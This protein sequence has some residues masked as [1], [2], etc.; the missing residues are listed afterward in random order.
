VS[1]PSGATAD[2]DSDSTQATTTSV[3]PSFSRTLPHKDSVPLAR[4]RLQIDEPTA[5]TSTN[6][7]VSPPGEIRLAFLLAFVA[8]LAWRV[9]S[10]SLQRGLDTTISVGKALLRPSS[11]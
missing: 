8:M 7:A 9:L 3:R 4:R 11:A 1:S 10:A 2:S 6:A 5:L